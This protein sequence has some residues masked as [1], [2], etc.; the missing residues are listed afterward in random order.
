MSI[1]SNNK[2]PRFEH[3]VCKPCWEIKY[4]PYG[5]LVEYF[6]LPSDELPISKIRNSWNSWMN[7][8]RSGKLQDERDIYEAIEKVLCLEPTR[9]EWISQY[10]TEELNC[11]NFGHICPVFMVAEGF[12]ETKAE[13]NT[14]RSISRQ[15][16]LK[17]IRRDGQVCRI[18]RKNV[19]DDEVE[20]DHIIPY[21]RGG[22]T[23]EDN[24]RLLCRSCNRKKKDSLA[25]ILE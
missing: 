19:P 18:C 25:E 5:P 11:N 2:K 12:T 6:P 22:Q 14:S 15:I 3:V 4:C 17:V 1:K 7:A 13:R 10:N 23:S 24:L 9:W 21:S 8:I 16:M 20:F